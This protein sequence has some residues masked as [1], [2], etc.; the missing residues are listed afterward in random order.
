MTETIDYL[1]H[2]EKYC[3][4]RFMST[5]SAG[6]NEFVTCS[7]GAC[8]KLYFPIQKDTFYDPDTKITYKPIYRTVQVL[9]EYEVVKQK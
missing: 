6:S 2:L 4:G 9:E 8:G 3:N 7:C 1:P 5:Y